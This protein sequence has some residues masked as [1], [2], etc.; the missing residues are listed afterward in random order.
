MDILAC[1]AKC[2][3]LFDSK[4]DENSTFCT[5]CEKKLFGE[6]KLHNCN[7]TANNKK[8]NKWERDPVRDRTQSTYMHYMFRV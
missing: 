2:D 8:K 6:K 7:S 3:E 5:D 4:V 1:K